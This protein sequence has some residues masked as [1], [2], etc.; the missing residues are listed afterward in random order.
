MIGGGALS[1]PLAFAQS[2]VIGGCL[3]LLFVASSA[4]GSIMKLIDCSSKNSHGSYEAVISSAPLF[5]GSYVVKY[6]CMGSLAMICWTGVVGYCVLLRDLAGRPMAQMFFH[7]DATDESASPTFCQNI[8]M[9]VIVALVTP[10]TM[11]RTL[12]S[13]QKVSMFGIASISLLGMCIIYKSIDCNFDLSGE[14]I[15]LHGSFSDFF[16]NQLW[17]HDW[18]DF[19]DALPIFVGPFMCHFNVLPVY[20]ELA[21]PSRERIRYI[22]RFATIFATSFYIVVG[23]SGSL[24][25]SCVESGQVEGNILLNFDDEHDE[26]MRFGKACL[27][28]TIALALPIMV[29]PCRDTLMRMTDD[30]EQD[31]LNISELTKHDSV[32]K[33]DE[34]IST[35]SD[36]S[37][38]N[39]NE[40]SLRVPLLDDSENPSTDESLMQIDLSRSS[41]IT[42]NSRCMISLVIFW[43]AA[44]LACVVESV[45]IVWE[46]SG[47]TL[48]IMIG[49]IAP[50]VSFLS[51]YANDDGDMKLKLRKIWGKM[52]ICLFIPI[53]VAC[54]SN[55]FLDIL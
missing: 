36:V 16:L 2:G 8:V 55:A 11:L 30:D 42:N 52:I 6:T 10:L 32:R 47:S 38:T 5:R 37:C 35:T 7:E 9:L 20:N 48:V 50:C 39:S 46:I 3:I 29:I 28:V 21:D 13:L 22:I 19:L 12:S 31:E 4:Y 15:N 25:G 27:T 24:Y 45:D 44:L 49:F 18:K 40:P 54:S 43:G 23:V 26:L 1:L 53:M 51:H 17:P 33:D 34:T 41:P 14:L